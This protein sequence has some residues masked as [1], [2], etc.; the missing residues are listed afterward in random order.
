MSI[1]IA[2]LFMVVYAMLGLKKPGVALITSPIVCVLLGVGVLADS[3]DTILLA[4]AIFLVTL[5][6]I[7]V[8]KR[9]PEMGQWPHL[10]AKLILIGLCALLFLVTISVLLFAGAAGFIILILF[11]GGTVFIGVLISLAVGHRRATAAIVLSTIGSSVRQNLP[12]PMALESAANGR[13]DSRAHIL[14]SIRKWLVQGYSLSESIKRGYPRCPGYAL[15]MI[16]SA[17]RFNQVPAALKALEA[18]MASRA[19]E[20]RR[21][22]PVHPWYPIAIIVFTLFILSGFMTFVLPQ[23]K[24]VLEEMLGRDMLPAPT[25]LLIEVMGS[26]W[27]DLGVLWVVAGIAIVM[28]AFVAI[29]VRFRPRRPENPYLLS[30]VGDFAKWY[31]PVLHWF[32]RNYSMVQVV[33]NLHLSLSAGCTVNDAIANTLGLDVNNRFKKRLRGWLMKVEAGDNIAAAARACK[34]GSPL[35]WAFDEKVNKGDT[36]AILETLESFYRSNYSYRVNMA[37]FIAWP[38]VTLALGIMVAFVV[39]SIFLPGITVINAMTGLVTP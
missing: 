4:P 10:A 25:R 8:G 6:A 19:D 9:E 39:V 28:A 38:C 21:L 20:R 36:L 11:I 27:Y 5:I 2:I 15:A 16:A 17:E 31:L 22:K 1:A 24:S 14:R 7:L 30:R 29:A 13:D 34:L 23:F 18:D 26:V 37:R 3:P 35:A 33:E 12:L 32:E